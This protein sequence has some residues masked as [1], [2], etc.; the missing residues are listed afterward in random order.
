MGPIPANRG[1]FITL[2]GGE[3]AGKSSQARLLGERLTALDIE[4]VLTREPGGSPWAEKLRRA[5]LS[6]AV[7]PMGEGAEALVF[8]AARIDHLD[9][10]IRPALARGAWVVCD[11]FI[12]STRAYQGAVGGLDPRLIRGLETIVVGDASPD[13]TL[14]LDLPPENGLARAAT[15]RGIGQTDRFE[16][17]NIDFHRRL[18]QAFMAIAGAEPDRCVAIDATQNIEE[19]ARDVWGVVDRILKPAQWRALDVG[20]SP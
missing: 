10:L 13:L 12:D 1:R 17:E 16:G 18:R 2:E 19:V 7:A 6:G 9:T 14:I 4:C 11:R 8:S 15:R 3:G 5:L 20:T